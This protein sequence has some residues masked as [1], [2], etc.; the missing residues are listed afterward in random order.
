MKFEE[1]IL[2]KF[3]KK[4]LILG[5]KKLFSGRNNQGKITVRHKGGQCSRN[6]RIIN[7]YFYYWN[8]YGIVLKFIYDPNRNSPLMLICYF[9]G[10]LSYQIAVKN[11]KIGDLIFIGDLEKKKKITFKLYFFYF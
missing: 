4:K 11:S 6:I 3:L 8:I 7:F 9:N 5:K 2:K 10:L 1:I